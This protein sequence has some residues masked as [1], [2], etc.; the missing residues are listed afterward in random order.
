VNKIK[1]LSSTACLGVLL[2]FWASAAGVNPASPATTT[3]ANNAPEVLYGPEDHPADRLVALY[4]GARKSIYLAMY[5][6]TYPPLVR[7]LVAA[8]KR[9]VDVRL[10]TDRGKLEERNQ[11]TALETLRLAG[12]P[13]K[14]NRYDG[15]MHMKQ[16]VIDE[17]VNT[18][19][20]M[21]QSSSAARFNDERLDILHDPISTQR[22]TKKFLSMWADHSRYEDWRQ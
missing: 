16:V 22:A 14:I 12:I 1:F 17:R 15:L 8:H 3:S 9:G 10:I 20:S 11:R 19:G 2:V 7:A 4:A 21:N 6:L 18:S 13:I 5:G